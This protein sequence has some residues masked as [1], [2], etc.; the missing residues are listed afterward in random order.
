[1][2]QERNWGEKPTG[3]EVSLILQGVVRTKSPMTLTH[4]ISGFTDNVFRINLNDEQYPRT[5]ILKEFLKPWHAKEADIYS[6][7]L[8]ADPALGTPKLIKRSG[9][10]ILLEYLDPRHYKPFDPGDIPLLIDWVKYKQEAYCGAVPEKYNQP[11]DTRRKYL[12]TNPIK[13]IG[14]MLS[15]REPPLD[16]GI[17]R[18]LIELESPLIQVLTELDKIPKTLEHCDLEPQN[19][20]VSKS[21]Q[22]LRVI[23]WVNARADCGLFDIAQLIE[24]IDFMGSQITQDCI[25]EALK[26]SYPFSVFT[27]RVRYAEMLTTLNKIEFYLSKFKAGE[28]IPHYD[29]ESLSLVIQKHANRLLNKFHSL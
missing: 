1:M 28:K 12:I 16:Q 19:L 6:E 22:R 5:F 15:D 2:I 4:L 20:F 17:I 23:D 3:T 29:K 7:I 14:T 26:G 11:I 24:N 9:K 8:Q 27:R 21:E 25:I 10:F 13:T 18:S